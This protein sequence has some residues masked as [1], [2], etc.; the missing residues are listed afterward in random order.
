MH[1]FGISGLVYA[2]L[3]AL[4]HL[5][6]A[7]PYTTSTIDVGNDVQLAFLDSGPPYHVNHTPY[8]TIFALHGEVYYSPVFAKIID[9]AQSSN[10]RFVAIT[11]R[12]YNG[13]TAYN[14]SEIEALS[15]GTAEDKSTFLQARGEEIAN[16]IV[17][18]ANRKLIPPVSPD[19]RS[20]GISLL[21][22]SFGN[23][24]SLATIA[25]INS[26]TPDVQRFLSSNLRS[27]ILHEPV[28]LAL[29]TPLA[30]GSWWPLLDT[31]IPASTQ[32]PALVQ[33]LTAYFQHG[34]LSTR[35]PGVLSLV[36]PSITRPPT[37]FNMTPSQL[38]GMTNLAPVAGSDGL[39]ILNCAPQ[40]EAS[41]RAALFDTTVRAALPN[42][43]ASLI[44]GDASVQFG[45]VGF[46]AVQAD[47]E[48]A[49]GGF[50][51]FH[52]I[53]GLN[54]FAHWDEPVKILSLYENSL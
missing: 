26:Y 45:I 9:L 44:V 28:P 39:L 53:H 34:N 25:N 8:T 15:N 48:A 13:S 52:L 17:R 18:F 35:D 24:F 16:F 50:V 47:D 43:R 11:R 6:Q 46:W 54:H 12:D 4:A 42:M 37:V 49:G 40:L 23:A 41:Y 31:S 22:W 29:G 20:G 19:G 1:T 7:L 2:S 33:W 30:P 36:L 10:V 21:G 14:A 38:E 5:T 3:F 32:G 27:L 51:Q